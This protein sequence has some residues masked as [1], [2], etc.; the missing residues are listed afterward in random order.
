[1]VTVIRVQIL[2]E[3][4]CIS[5]ST[6]TLGKGMKLIILLPA[7]DKEWDRQRSLTLVRQPVKEKE[8]RTAEPRLKIDFASYPARVELSVSW[9]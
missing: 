3:A 2:N 1:M 7:R 9:V 5:H 4:V 6:N 8:F